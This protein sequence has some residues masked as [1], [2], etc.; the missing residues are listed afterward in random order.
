MV[1]AMPGSSGLKRRSR[2]KR[3]GRGKLP[4]PG[5]ARP[6]PTS[7]TCNLRPPAPR[8]VRGAPPLQLAAVPGQSD[9]GCLRRP[10]RSG[11]AARGRVFGVVSCGAAAG[12][13]ATRGGLRTR[14]ST[15]PQQL[16]TQQETSRHPGASAQCVSNSWSL[17]LRSQKDTQGRSIAQQ[18]DALD[19]HSIGGQPG[20][21]ADVL[22]QLFR[23]PR[24]EQR[25]IVIDHRR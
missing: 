17:S 20:S 21:G 19:L 12:A 10:G 2:G 13:A 22:Q 3:R 16:G 6:P 24:F 14:S 11:P 1:T 9:Y 25:Q 8:R 18:I 7:C 15:P 4:P 5:P 23:A